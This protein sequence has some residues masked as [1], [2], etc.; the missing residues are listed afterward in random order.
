M[1]PCVLCPVTVPRY[2]L[3]L[4]QCCMRIVCPGDARREK[5]EEHVAAAEL[6]QAAA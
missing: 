2:G 5:I 6:L 1:L 3:D 4:L